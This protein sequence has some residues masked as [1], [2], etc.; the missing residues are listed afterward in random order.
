MEHVS[1]SLHDTYLIIT[2]LLKGEMSRLTIHVKE[3]FS[4]NGRQSPSEET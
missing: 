1:L 4:P 2:D 3:A